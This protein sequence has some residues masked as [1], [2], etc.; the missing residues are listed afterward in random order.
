MVPPES[1]L[2]SDG[3]VVLGVAWNHVDATLQV[4]RTTDGRSREPIEGLS[5]PSDLLNIQSA[6]IAVLGDRAVIVAWVSQL[7]PSDSE[8]V[9][10]LEL[11]LSFRSP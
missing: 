8:P 2:A 11:N 10:P 3:G 9:A 7:L 1:R 5:F 4:W 6:D